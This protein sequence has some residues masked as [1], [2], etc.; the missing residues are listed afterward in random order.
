[1]QASLVKADGKGRV[2]IRGI[3]KGQQYL[4]TCEKG[5]WWVAPAPKVK[6]PPRDMESLV[7]ENWKKLGPGPDIDYDKI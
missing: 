1:M 6:V 4:V 2:S 3:K 7:A 5:G